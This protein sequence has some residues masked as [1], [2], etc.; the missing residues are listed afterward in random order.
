MDRA[1][2]EYDA[3]AGEYAR[4]ADQVRAMRDGVDDIRAT[5]YSDDGLVSAVVG[6]RGEVVELELDPRVYRDQNPAALAETI[7]ATI[8]AAAEEAEQSAIRFAEKLL[9]ARRGGDIDPMFDPVLHMLEDR[10]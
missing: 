9:P 4:I 7:L 8:H 1:A 2:A 3:R 6:G 5:A 10:R